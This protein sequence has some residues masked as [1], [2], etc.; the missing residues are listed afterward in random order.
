VTW[1]RIESWFAAH[2]PDLRLGLRPPATDAQL[3][4]AERTLG[5]RF[6]ADFRAAYLEHDGQQDAPQVY[7]LPY[8]QRIGSLASLT[9][10]WQDDAPYRDD[11]ALAET[12]GLLDEEGRVRQ[13]YLHPGHIPFAGSPHWDYDRLCLDHAPGPGGSDGQ[14]IARVDID[15]VYVA[16]SLGALLD[17]I[18]GGLADGTIEVSDAGDRH[19]LLFVTPE[20]KEPIPSSTWW[21]ERAKKAPPQAGG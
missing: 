10:C 12:S 13:V 1:S 6:P 7:V 8:V 15:L 18:A 4:E 20:G 3:D 14:V 5:V 19:E 11:A 9:K 21:A 2:R 16:P 17:A